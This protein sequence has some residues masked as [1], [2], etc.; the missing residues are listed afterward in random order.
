VKSPSRKSWRYYVTTVRFQVYLQRLAGRRI[1]A[2]SE[3]PVVECFSTGRAP[4]SFH[5]DA[6]ANHLSMANSKQSRCDRSL[7][8]A[9]TMFLPS[10][11]SQRLLDNE[12][13]KVVYAF[14]FC[15][16]RAR[17]NFRYSCPDDFGLGIDLPRHSLHFCEALTVE[18][19][20]SIG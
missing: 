8:Q 4:G 19:T 1:G 6:A 20:S 2:Y 5:P 17:C 13:Q 9:S 14:G 16:P 7:I 15:E 12:S 3:R 11:D 10:V 18:P